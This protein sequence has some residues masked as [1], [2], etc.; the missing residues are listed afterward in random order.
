MWPA[1]GTLLPGNAQEA[2]GMGCTEAG[3]GGYLW[4]LRNVP[5]TYILIG[6]RLKFLPP[7]SCMAILDKGCFPPENSL[8][9]V[10]KQEVIKSFPDSPTPTPH[11]AAK[12]LGASA[13]TGVVCSAITYIPPPPPTINTVAATLD[14]KTSFLKIRCF[15]VLQRLSKIWKDFAL[16]CRWLHMPPLTPLPESQCFAC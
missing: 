7:N 16:V 1:E 9:R 5:A 10:G 3:S 13:G 8:G 15:S 12:R 2:W 4:C 14:F 6:H 11:Q